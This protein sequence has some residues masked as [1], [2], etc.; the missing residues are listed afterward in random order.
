MGHAKIEKVTGGLQRVRLLAI[1]NRWVE[2]T[3]EFVAS[4]LTKK[5][6]I[7]TRNPTGSFLSSSWGLAISALPLIPKQV[8]VC[9]DVHLCDYV[10]GFLWSIKTGLM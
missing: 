1:S 6:N 5:F 2:L 3:E 7:A 10:S 4:W 9:I 8:D